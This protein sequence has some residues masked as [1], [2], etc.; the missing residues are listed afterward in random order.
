MKPAPA[1]T[2]V[3]WQQ[4][5]RILADALDC[6]DGGERALFVKKACG[7][8]PALRAEVESLLGQQ[9]GGLERYAAAAGALCEDHAG[10]AAANIGRRLG[11]YELVRELGRGGM[12][13][14]YLARRADGRFEQQVAIKLLKRGTDTEEVMRRFRF[15]RRLLARLEHPNIARLFD[16]G[17]SEDGLPFFVMEHVPGTPLTAFAREHRLT[18]RARLEL[19]IKV[20]V[21]VQ[22]AHQSLIVHRDLKPGNILVNAAGEP[23]LLDFGIARFLAGPEDDPGTCQTTAAAQRHL[24]PAYASPE[25]VRGEPITTVS[26]VYSLGALLYE[27]LTGEPPH[28]FHHAPPAPAELLEVVG[29]QEPVLPSLAASEAD[30]RRL[31]R[32]DLDNIIRRAMGKEPDRRYPTANALAEELRRHLAGRPV[33]ARPDTWRYRTTKFVGRN[34]KAAVTAGMLAFVMAGGAF[35]TIWQARRAERH[36]REVRQLTNSYLF[37]IQDAIRDLPGSTPAR[38]LIVSRALEYLDRLSRESVGD[39]ELQLELAGAYLQVGDVQGKP[40]APNLGDT[41]NALLSYGKAVEI[42]GPLAAVE[43]GPASKARRVLGQARESLGCI[44]SRL[45]RWEEATSNHHQALAIRMALLKEDPAH[46][47]DWRRGIIADHIG[48]GDAIVSANRFHPVAGHQH[49]AMEHYRRALPLCEQLFAAHPE[50][51]ANSLCLS[52]VCSRIA[53]ESSEIGSLEKNPAAYKESVVFHR[54]ALALDE[55]CLHADPTSPAFKRR[56]ADEL[57]ATSYL[58]AMSGEDLPEA[59]EGCRKALELTENIASLDPA[60]AEARQDLSSAYFVAARVCQAQG[61]LPT[62]AEH[63]RH[64]LG[65]LEP[66]VA[67]HP[68]N[69]E[70]AFDLGRVHQG[71]KEVDPPAAVVINRKLPES[72]AR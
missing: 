40:Y 38:R 13:A 10:A 14:V 4:I 2:A 61:D 34:K 26:D 11:A 58:A 21:A 27:L 25:Q 72:L 5:K 9:T 52:K 15:E 16:G 19:F 6:E 71:L 63:Y 36:Y 28:R 37:E 1:M 44:Q 53:T 20:C 31:L 50:S 41:A 18:M 59:L 69:V 56:L 45:N 60:N 7:E 43:H 54:R 30:T 66:L 68:G 49:L 3:R 23:K 62:A 22:V 57:V 35:T 29:R 70:T 32:G 42:A 47:D 33:H 46:A 24:T 65:I 55:A 48:L 39:G 64:A 8:D 17:E 12:G 67:E 51:L